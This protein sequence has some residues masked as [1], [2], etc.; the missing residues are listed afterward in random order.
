MAPEEILL[1]VFAVIL[2]FVVQSLPRRGAD[3]VA[4]GPCNVHL[5]PDTTRVPAAIFS[6]LLARPTSGV[7][8]SR[9][10]SPVCCLPAR[11]RHG[12]C[13]AISWQNA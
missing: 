13:D 5:F 10:H 9:R 4:C 6:P 11:P 1:I 7:L 3:Q 8:P 2:F 12:L